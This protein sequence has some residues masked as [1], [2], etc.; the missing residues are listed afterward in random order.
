LGNH[1]K[2]IYYNAKMKEWERFRV[3]VTDWELEQYLDVL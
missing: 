1:A 3:R 2:E